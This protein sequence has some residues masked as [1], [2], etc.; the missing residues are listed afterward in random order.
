MVKRYSIL[1]GC[2]LLVFTLMEVV[3]SETHSEADGLYVTT[4][5]IILDNLLPII[6]KRVME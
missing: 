6:D 2:L 1:L 3:K 5:D 4:E